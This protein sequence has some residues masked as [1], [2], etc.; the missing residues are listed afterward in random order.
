MGP[1]TGTFPLERYAVLA[2]DER[3]DVSMRRPLNAIQRAKSGTRGVIG[4]KARGQRQTGQQQRVEKKSNTRDVEQAVER[5]DYHKAG[6][7][8]GK[9]R[10]ERMTTS[11]PKRQGPERGSQQEYEQRQPDHTL[12]EEQV[13][14][15]IL[16][17]PRKVIFFADRDP[18]RRSAR[19]VAVGEH[20][21]AVSADD[22]D[23][24]KIDRL[25]TT[26]TASENNAKRGAYHGPRD[27]VPASIRVE[28]CCHCNPAGT[29]TVAIP[30]VPL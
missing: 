26:S 28:S 4:L 2:T 29:A 15:E 7:R 9:I 30:Q 21:G 13:E 10:G 25:S 6:H 17:V 12:I 24:S 27:N 23:V 11:A 18:M 8:G 16:D 5:A 3:I 14:G 20:I 19:K 1:L 22:A